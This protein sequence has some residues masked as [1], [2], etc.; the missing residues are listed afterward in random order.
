VVPWILCGGWSTDAKIVMELKDIAVKRNLILIL[1]RRISVQY[2]D[3][4]D[5]TLSSSFRFCGD[6]IVSGGILDI[7]KSDF[8][9]NPIEMLEKMLNIVKESAERVLRDSATATNH[10]VIDYK[11]NFIEIEPRLSYAVGM[12]IGS[13]TTVTDKKMKINSSG[14]C[15]ISDESIA[16]PTP[17]NNFVVE[18]ATTKNGLNVPTHSH[19]DQQE[20]IRL[21]SST[22]GTVMSQVTLILQVC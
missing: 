11:G 6:M 9:Q 12:N 19:A 13:L 22:D 20:Y 21:A 16:V 10:V 14:L 1:S 5:P 4:S 3:P 2:T 7:K 15:T 17:T 18:L 8:K